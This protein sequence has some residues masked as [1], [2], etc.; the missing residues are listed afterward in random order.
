MTKKKK[1]EILHLSFPDKIFLE[2]QIVRKREREKKKERERF[3]WKK[4][5]RKVQ[6]QDQDSLLV[7]R[8]NDNHSPGHFQEEP[9]AEVAANPL[10]Q[11]EERKRHRP[12]TV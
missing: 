11:E 10:H 1:N 8:R 12:M 9:Q 4:V 5:N 3:S 6:D 2:T 7:K